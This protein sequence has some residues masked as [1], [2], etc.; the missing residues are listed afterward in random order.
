MSRVTVGF[1]W[2]MH[3]PFYK[4]PLSNTY[5]MPW[6]RLHAIRGYYD[7]IKILG[8]YPSVR[9]TFNL[10]PCF[11]SQIIDYTRHG[12]RDTDFYLSLKT[13]GELSLDEKRLIVERFF[14]CNQDTM[15]KPLPRYLA[16]LEKRGGPESAIDLKHFS[17]QDIV[18]LQVLFNL[19]WTGFTARKDEGIA[20]LLKKGSSYSEADKLYLL[21]FHL[22]IM[23]KI[24]DLY[25]EALGAGQIEITTS[26][27]YHPIGPLLMNVG[28]ALRSMD[29]PLPKEPFSHPEDLR[30]QIERAVDFH[31]RLFDTPPKGMWPAEGSVCPEMIE[32]FSNN[33]I[34]WAATDEDILFGSIQQPRTGGLLHRPYSVTHGEHGLSMFFRDRPLSDRI[35]FVYAKNKPLD[36]VDDFMHHLENI[37][38]GAKGYDFEPFVSIILDGENPWEYYPDSGEGFLRGLYRSLSDHKE[39]TTERFGAFLDEHPPNKNI[40]KLYTGSWINHDFAIWIGH[41]EDRKAWEYLAKT[42][43]YVESKAENADELAWEEIYIAEGS[44]WCWWYGEEFSTE[45]DADFDQ[46]YRLHLQNCYKLHNDIYPPYLSQSIIS[47]HD[48]TPRKYPEGFIYPLV[49]GKISNFYEWR[50][51]G[52]YVATSTTASMYRYDRAIQQIFYGFDPD[53]F[54]LRIDFATEMPDAQ[55]RIN[56]LSP[57]IRFF[58]I[59]KH[60]E[61]LKL[62]A[63][64]DVQAKGAPIGRIALDSVLEMTMPLAVFGS[65]PGEQIRFFIALMQGDMEIERHP[66]T[67]VLTCDHPGPDFEREMWHV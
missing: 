55:L 2:H 17:D 40:A 66:A 32:L 36:A 56:V 20:E 50:R 29:T 8:E 6:V 15:I 22:D 38:R 63:F 11:L 16:L 30:M 35:S 46:L 43:K 26:P 21:N 9:C 33:G 45:N 1:L 60:P 53:N 23:G 19:A 14:R 48:I 27:F 10:V 42:R 18:D 65:S 37:R 54:Y 7:M 59:S 31:A 57:Q 24:I 52:W 47:P 62:G 58:S 4:D 34:Q 3:Q 12:F 41:E 25:K 13:P 5:T 51:A 49:D 44:D 64:D 61:G 28:Y 67:G 39:I